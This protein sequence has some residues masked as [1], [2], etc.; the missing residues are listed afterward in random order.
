MRQTSK[1]LNRCQYAHLRRLVGQ[2]LAADPAVQAAWVEARGIADHERRTPAG[3][4]WE[5]YHTRVDAGLVAAMLR[6]CRLTGLECRIVP[7]AG[8]WHPQC[9]RIEVTRPADGH[10]VDRGRGGVR[11]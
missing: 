11:L 5:P 1:Y 4:V 2:Q 10:Q 7:Y 6:F 9:H 8:D 3:V